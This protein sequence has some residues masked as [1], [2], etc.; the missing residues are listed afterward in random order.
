MELGPPP[1]VFIV[2]WMDEILRHLRN[3]GMVRFPNVNTEIT[4]IVSFPS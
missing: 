3:P 2:L 4:L 1:S